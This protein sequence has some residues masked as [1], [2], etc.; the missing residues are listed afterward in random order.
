MSGSEP[1]LEQKREGM[2]ECGVKRKTKTARTQSVTN[3]PD[4]GK[5]QR[6]LW[7]MGREM[8]PGT[9]EKIRDG[10]IYDVREF[11]SPDPEPNG[12]RK[13]NIGFLHARSHLR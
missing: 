3:T 10:M 12:L 7:K 2:L 5:Q 9:C 4:A 1:F 8:T 13:D 11:S 6:E